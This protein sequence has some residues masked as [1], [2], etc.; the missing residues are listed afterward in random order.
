[1]PVAKP[2]SAL[3]KPIPL[4]MPPKG[5]LPGDE[6]G[7]VVVETLI[8]CIPPSVV[9]KICTASEPAPA[10]RSANS[11]PTRPPATKRISPICP[12]LASRTVPRCHVRPPSPVWMMMAV[13]GF[14]AAALMSAAHATWAVGK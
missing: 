7:G 4:L 5:R 6:R 3:R 11:Q 1:M 9:R 10:P 13:V 8:H 14:G 12:G 2:A